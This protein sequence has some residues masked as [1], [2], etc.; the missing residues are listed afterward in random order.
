MK[1]SDKSWQV[2]HFITTAIFIAAIAAAIYGIAT[3]CPNTAGYISCAA[4]K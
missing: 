3:D 1:L 4:M 2:L